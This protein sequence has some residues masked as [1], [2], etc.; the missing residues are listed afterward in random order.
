MCGNVFLESLLPSTGNTGV[1]QRTVK[2]KQGRNDE[3]VN[4]G[5]EGQ[6]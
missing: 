4:G 2:T 5:S 6:K 1:M 3:N